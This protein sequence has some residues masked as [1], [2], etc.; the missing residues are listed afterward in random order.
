MH[1]PVRIG[2]VGAGAIAQ[3]YLKVLENCDFATLT[4][5]ADLR[6]Q[7]AE[8]AAEAAGAKAFTKAESMLDSGLVDAVVVCTPPSTHTEIGMAVLERGL[9]LL[10]EKPLCTDVADAL[11][12][13]EAAAKQGVVMTMA[14]KFRYCE[15]V[16]RTKSLIASGVLGR[17]L[18]VETSFSAQVDMT[19]RW[20]S[21][22]R[23][24]GG[25][26]LI[27][28]GT[29]SVDVIRYLLGPVAQVFALET[30]RFQDTKVEDTVDLFVVTED[31]C[32]VRVDLTWSIS[33]GAETYIDI[34]GSD[35]TV[36]VGWKQSRYRQNSGR[37]W[38]VFG[39][40][41]DK[42]AAFRANL[43]N[44]CMA[45][46]GR[47]PLLITAD[48]AIASVEVIQRAYESLQRQAWVSVAPPEVT[49]ERLA[50]VLR[51]SA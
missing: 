21:D 8:A 47:E 25:G 48:D 26:V 43:R 36:H 19:N 46:E 15:D 16:V 22:P 6:K 34:Y 14:S 38:V 33:K 2:L 35:G 24:S 45:I 13:R 9:H 1:N 5:I 23:A 12:L 30:K 29:H 49:A 18:R 37:D 4:A 20:N 11:K 31:G 40:G 28:N 27:D 41:Y 42:L 44:F 7:S 50:P 3:S 32:P 51:I 39:Q 10:C 17:I